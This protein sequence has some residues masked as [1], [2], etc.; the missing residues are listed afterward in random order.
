[1]ALLHDSR[2]RAFDL[3]GDPLVGASLTV[4]TA[5][6]TSLASV[7][8][9][10]DLDD[11]MSNPTSL[12][13]LSGADGYFPQIFAS[14]G[15]LFDIT[16]KDANGVTMETWLGVPGLGSGSAVIFRDFGSSRMQIADSGGVV[17]VE[18]GP[19][20]GDD[21]GGQITIGGW[22]GSQA[23]EVVLDGANTRT[24]G[25]LAT[26]GIITENSKSL[27]GVVEATGIVTGATEAIIALPVVPAGVTTW[28]LDLRGISVTSTLKMQIS[29]DNGA[30]WLS[31]SNY[32]TSYSVG[33]TTTTGGGTEA[34]LFDTTGFGPADFCLRFLTNATA[35]LSRWF[36]YG[37]TF[38]LPRCIQTAG[39]YTASIARVTH[40]R[41]FPASGT[42]S[43]AYR[44][45]P[46]R[47]A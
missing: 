13:D 32:S 44:T 36:G 37:Q 47:D 19:A 33:G 30:T 20:V 15:A 40:I 10:S 31:A 14:E 25:P 6:T 11:P 39:L 28:D 43:L 27:A 2:F 46:A 3:N 23:D 4:Y 29:I 7:W 9:N 17:R 41:L 42:I 1:M 12:A 5:N 45:V 16:L 38:T 8:R 24:T 26:G 35:G 34:I 18:G 22:Q 21:I